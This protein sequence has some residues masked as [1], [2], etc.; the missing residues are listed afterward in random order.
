VTSKEWD[1][2]LNH[3]LDTEDF[4]IDSFHIRFVKSRTYVWIGNY[5]YAFGDKIIFLKDFYECK[6]KLPTRKTVFRLYDKIYS[7]KYKADKP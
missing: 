7:G 5:P 6:D 3:L 1:R 2:E 4:E